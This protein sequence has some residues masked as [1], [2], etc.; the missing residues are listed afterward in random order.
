MADQRILLV[1]GSD[2]RHVL[3]AICEAR[4]IDLPDEIRPHGGTSDLLPAITRQL[5]ASRG[6]GDIVGVVLDADHDLDA[7]WESVCYRLR[8]TG[9]DQMPSAPCPDGTIIQPPNDSPLVKV[10]V[11]IW[12]DNSSQGILE[13]FLR[14]LVPAQDPLLPHAD[15]V[16]KSLPDYRFTQNERPKAIIHTWLAWQSDPG[17][18]YGTAITAGFLDACVPRVGL[19]VSWLRRLFHQP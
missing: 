14:V 9:Y 5:E 19:L 7:R 10:G 3:R 1:E 11:W 18:P 13:D 2:D 15:S 6:E 12:P 8:R 16:V 4:R 17:R